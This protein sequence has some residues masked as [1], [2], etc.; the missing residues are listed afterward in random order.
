MGWSALRKV[1]IWQTADALKEE[2]M[3]TRASNIA[4]AKEV[5]EKKETYDDIYNP[6]RQEKNGDNLNES[7]SSDEIDT[8]AVIESL[9]GSSLSSSD[10][11]L[12]VTENHISSSSTRDKLSINVLPDSPKYTT[13]S[14]SVDHK[15]YTAEMYA[16]SPARDRAGSEDFIS[17]SRSNSTD[18]HMLTP[19][20][21]GHSFAEAKIV[22]SIAETSELHHDCMNDAETPAVSA[23][24]EPHIEEKGSKDSNKG[25]S[26]KDNTILLE[27]KV[28]INVARPHH[29][30]KLESLSTKMEELRRSMLSEG[31]DS[32]A[33]WDATGKPRTKR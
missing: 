15:G 18:F 4:D 32:D 10:G 22:S 28:S 3:S 2:F 5:A 29:V 30:P 26:S 24:D 23:R 12:Q 8:K 20:S 13:S 33:P 1:G 7:Y 17:R 25:K 21:R 31:L 9:V 14:D 6:Y 16:N 11:D 19:S 27:R